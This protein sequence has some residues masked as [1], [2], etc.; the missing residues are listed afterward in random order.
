MTYKLNRVGT[1]HF[2]VQ[3]TILSMAPPGAWAGWSEAITT[4][5]K[6]VI[7]PNGTVFTQF[8]HVRAH[9][10]TPAALTAGH[11]ISIGQA[12]QVP[13]VVSGNS[14]GL[15]F[16][17]SIRGSVPLDTVFSHTFGIA[18]AAPSANWDTELVGAATIMDTEQSRLS[19]T[20]IGNLAYE[21]KTQILYKEVQPTIQTKILSHQIEIFSASGAG[22]NV[23]NLMVQLAFRSILNGRELENFDPVR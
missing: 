2:F 13:E 18:A 5:S 14:I 11:Q 12:C 3:G 21:N 4:L 20:T 22:G 17:V 6:P 15:E 19:A 7:Y 9:I 8:G 1:P 23:G 16:A 10:T